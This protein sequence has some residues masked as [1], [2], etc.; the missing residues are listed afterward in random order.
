MLQ[1]CAVG[2]CPNRSDTIILY[3]LPED[4][5]RRSAWMEFMEDTKA[6][7]ENVS[8]SC[9]V[10][11]DHFSED[12]Y[13][14]L[15]LGY[16]T[17]K[18]LSVDAVPTILSVNRSCETVN[19]IQNEE[20]DDT[21][22]ITI[23]ETISLA[24][25]KEE[26]LEFD[27]NCSRTPQDDQN[28]SLEDTV[29]CEESELTIT[30][31]MDMKKPDQDAKVKKVRKGGRLRSFK[32][33]ACGQKFRGRGALIQH[34]R[35]KHLKQK[36]ES[37]TQEKIIAC[38]T[39]T[40]KFPKMGLS[41]QHSATHTAIDTEGNSDKKHMCDQCGKS[42]AYESFLK[43]HQKVH[44]YGESVL[45]FACHLCPRRFGYKV[46]LVAHLRQHVRKTESLCPIC[47][48]SFPVQE[49]PASAHQNISCYEKTLL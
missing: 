8:S 40:E 37:V 5:K 31:D 12:C 38:S 9:R 7:G 4:P 35:E 33:L 20:T 49:F 13:F 32:C 17:C 30:E 46:A 25:V 26:P 6:N 28:S 42:F 21:C 44:E 47:E 27:L 18:I 11:G 34:Q 19:S 36:S 1:K 10:C 3:I 43:V 16:T 23:A 29:K 48:K 24:C 14:K 15:D 45:P 22:A 39:P 2:G 41:M